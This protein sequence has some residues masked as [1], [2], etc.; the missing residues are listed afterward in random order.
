MPQTRVEIF[1]QAITPKAQSNLR[2]QRYLT[3]KPSLSRRGSA[4]TQGCTCIPSGKT[5]TRTAASASPGPDSKVCSTTATLTLFAE[6]FPCQILTFLQAACLLYSQCCTAALVQQSGSKKVYGLQT[7]A[8]SA[9]AG[10][11]ARQQASAHDRPYGPEHIQD[12]CSQHTCDYHTDFNA[13]MLAKRRQQLQSEQ[14]G[15]PQQVLPLQL[16]HACIYGVFHQLKVQL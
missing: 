16:A 9:A 14:Q 10:T 11:T 7:Q 15:L 3:F 2:Q 4:H 6:E 12:Y 13:Q 5:S 1:S 8:M